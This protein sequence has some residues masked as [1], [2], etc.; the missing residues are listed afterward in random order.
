M[1][2]FLLSIL[3]LASLFYLKKPTNNRDWRPEQS[4]LSSAK[5]DGNEIFI[6]N[7]RNCTYKSE[8][9]FKLNYYDKKFDLKKIKS[10]DLVLQHIKKVP[11]AAH[12][13]LSFGFEGGE[14]LSVSIEARR[15]KNKKYSIFWGLF[16][17]FELIY[18]IA[19]ESDIMK[20]R[21]LHQKDKIF[22]YPLNIEK[23]KI[24]NI[25]VDILA[26]ANKTKDKPEF[27]NSFIN[28]CVTNVFNHIKK[29]GS[30][31]MPKSWRFLFPAVLDK[32]MYD[33]NMIKTNL[34]FEDLRKKHLI[35]QK[36]EK[37]KNESDYSV[38]IRS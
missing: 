12:V 18:I 26:R 6:K 22:I 29:G 32:F 11:L 24:E 1:T 4:K 5:I 2:I 14:Y 23:E 30:I 7:I 13:F 8:N 21:P 37:H 38:K 20:L 28:S 15:K 33:I 9:D 17:S 16:K 34:S 27:Y 3:I 31:E 36:A 10:I 35:N 25:F 19:D